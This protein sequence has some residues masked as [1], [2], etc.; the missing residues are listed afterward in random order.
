MKIKQEH[1]KYIQTAICKDGSA[2]YLQEYISNGLT[3][4]RWRW[5]LLNRANISKWICENI[6]PYA[7]DDH[8]DSALRH[9]TGTR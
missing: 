9:I 5:D 7:N 4:K 2:P 3:A 6:Y 8:I 1:I